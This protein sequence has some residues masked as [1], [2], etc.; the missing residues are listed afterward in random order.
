MGRLGGI[1]HHRLR[2]GYMYESV[3]RGS[4][5]IIVTDIIVREGVY[6]SVQ[7]GSHHQEVYMG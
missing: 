5:H 6:N 4:S 2:G 7:W 3:Q 1:G